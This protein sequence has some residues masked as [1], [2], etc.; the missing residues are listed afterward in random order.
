MK[1]TVVLMGSPR[2]QSN[3]D[4]LT[5]RVIEGIRA[6]GSPDDIIHKID[7]VEL[8]DYVCCAC[9]RCRAAGECLQFPQVTEV[10]KL[11]K[12]ADGLVLATPVW[13]LGPSSLLK[14][15]LD[16]WGALLRPDYSSRIAGKRA[17][18]VACCGNPQENLGEKVCDDLAGVLS[19]LG[20]KV[21]GSLSVKGVAEYGEVAGDSRSLESAFQLGQA[22]Y[23][24]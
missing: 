7:L 22:L 21:I 11:I 15:F 9:G 8:Q 18:L 13:W 24:R 10:L 23:S 14:I 19:F 1:R 3:T 12:K 17:V 5:G 16:H 20:V 4:I 2:L 6:A